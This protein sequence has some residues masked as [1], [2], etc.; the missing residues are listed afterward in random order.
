MLYEELKI[1]DIVCA[2]TENGD[3]DVKTL[4][5][6]TKILPKSE[7]EGMTVITVAHYYEGMNNRSGY[8]HYAP[9]DLS[10]LDTRILYHIMCL[11]PKWQY[12]E[13]IIKKGTI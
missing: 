2:K 1:G 8:T 9:K 5:Q 6:I 12:H 3:L 7:Y 11:M 4:G 13:N 10:L